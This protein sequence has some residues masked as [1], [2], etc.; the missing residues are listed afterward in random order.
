MPYTIR[1]SDCAQSSGKKGSY[2]VSYTDKHG[3]KHKSCHTSKKKAQGQIAA[4]EMN[5]DDAG[6]TVSEALMEYVFE[7]LEELLRHPGDSQRAPEALG[8]DT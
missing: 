2:T 7:T 3:K 6:D 4:I 1:K 5:E 8:R